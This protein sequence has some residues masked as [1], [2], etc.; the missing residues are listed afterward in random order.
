ALAPSN[1]TEQSQAACVRGPMM[2]MLPSCQAPSKNVHVFD[3]LLPSGKGSSVLLASDSHV[4]RNPLDGASGLDRSLS[5]KAR[6][7]L[8]G[9][10]LKGESAQVG[11]E[12]IILA[13]GAVCERR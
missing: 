11:G 1:T 8:L 12:H 7:L 10:D 13:L 4:S 5:T 6:I 3:Q 9:I 2:P